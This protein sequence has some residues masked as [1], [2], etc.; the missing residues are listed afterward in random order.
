MFSAVCSE[1]RTS[2]SAVWPATWGEWQTLGRLTSG[3]LSP[4]LGIGIGLAYL[5]REVAQE[6]T[7]LEIEVRGRM[8]PA[9]VVKKPFY[10]KP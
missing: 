7:P 5:S 2:D 6:G 4:S 8:I 9:E 10:K 1:T 3:T